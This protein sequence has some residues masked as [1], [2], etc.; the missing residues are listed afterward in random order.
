MRI[1]HI[2]NI[3]G[4]ASRLALAQR[5]LGHEALVFCLSESPYK[6]P[7][8]IRLGRELP[9]GWNLVMTT[10]WRRLSTF[11]VIHVHGGLWRSQ[12]F[13]LLFK[14]RFPGKTLAVHFH[15]TETRSGKGLYYM[16]L[17]DL[18]FHS[19]PDLA[20]Y[21]PG[22]IWVP[23]PIVVPPPR[24]PADNPVPR[25]GHFV[26]S[27]VLKG[28][29]RVV[30]LFA[31][32][33]GPLEE[34]RRGNL[35]NYRGRDAELL[36]VVQVPHEEA[37]THMQSCDAVIDQYAEFGIY[38]NVAI[39]AMAF[40]MPVLGTPRLEWYPGCPIVPLGHD[41]RDQLRSIAFDARL[42]R[43][44]GEEGRRYVLH[45]HD[46]RKVAEQVMK[47]YYKSQKLPRLSTGE[48]TAYWK[49]RGRGYAA[50]LSAPKL[51]PRYEE[52]ARELLDVLRGLEFRSVG[53]VGC[54]F[55][56]IGMALKDCFNVVWTGFDLSR[57]QLTTLRS[58]SAPL[59]ARAVVASAGRLPLGDEIVDLVLTVEMMMHI[60]PE[61]VKTVMAELFRV[62]RRY[63]VH[64]DWYE[65]YLPG[66]E[67]GW[68]WMHDYP[69]LWQSMGVTP[70]QIRVRSTGIQSVFIVEKP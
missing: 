5:R 26:T 39:E 41:P 10:Q 63:V 8:D 2:N 70:R 45:A 46:S 60:P 17:P 9:I 36:V 37:L 66:Y 11:D 1:A 55:G 30:S 4:V 64:L 28:T 7:C 68:C 38:G 32:A 29:P 14:R 44:L 62:A 52:Q 22:S 65:D 69:G 12:L 61:R 31:E 20:R 47:E 67:T 58:R 13:Y 23:N 25:F 50:E 51:R 53:E 33:F 27:S 43:R 42:R 48:S 57:D 21:L 19:T 6:F 54:G 18:K 3:A 15:G 34:R 59:G 35:I 49:E 16:G 40:G 24:E 56:R